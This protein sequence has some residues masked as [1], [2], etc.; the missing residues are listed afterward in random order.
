[1]ITAFHT[2]RFRNYTGFHVWT[3]GPGFVDPSLRVQDVTRWR[4]FPKE[5]VDDVAWFIQ[6]RDQVIYCPHMLSSGFVKLFWVMFYD[7]AFAVEFKMRTE[8]SP[9]FQEV[10]LADTAQEVL[11]KY[12]KRKKKIDS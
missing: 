2:F 7:D 12:L 4:K 10:A 3:D 11:R 9:S 5:G 1:M 6:N 8:L